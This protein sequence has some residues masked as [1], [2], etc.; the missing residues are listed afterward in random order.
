VPDAGARQEPAFN[1]QLVELTSLSG[2]RL[3]D[4]DGLSAMV[5]AAAGAVGMPA[6]GPPQVRESPAGVAIALLCRGG[7]IVIQTSPLEGLCYV[8]VV[9]RDPADAAKAIEVIS[10]G[11]A[12]DGGQRSR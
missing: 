3:S 12:R 1:H 6:L 8:D 9:A 11:F 4:T 10:R 2:T 7:H 5:V